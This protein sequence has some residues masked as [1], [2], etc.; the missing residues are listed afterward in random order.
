MDPERDVEGFRLLFVCTGNTCRSP[1]AEVITRRALAERGWG[2]VEVR[3]AGVATHAGLPASEGALRSGAR[4]GLDLSGH[5][6]NA[7]TPELVEWAD[8]I[9]T[10]GPNHLSRTLELGGEGRATLLTAFAAGEEEDG[11]DHGG[12]ADPFGGDDQAYEE[13]YEALSALVEGVLGRLAP[14]LAP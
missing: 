11:G 8:L 6:T 14:I 7:L 3:S 4:H 13:T 2:G 9:L 5:R 1:L 12:V 10:M